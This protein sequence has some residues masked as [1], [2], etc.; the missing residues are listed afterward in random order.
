[1]SSE[2]TR[3][4]LDNQDRILRH[5]RLAGAD[6][7]SSMSDVLKIRKSSVTSICRELLDRGVLLE[8]EPGVFRSP[9]GLDPTY[10]KAAVLDIKQSGATTAIVTV[11]GTIEHRA[12][13][14]APKEGASAGDQLKDHA[15]NLKS[16]IADSGASV[17]GVGC[18]FPGIT[19]AETGKSV[20][21]INLPSGWRDV[22][23]TAPLQSA[24]SLGVTVESDAS[25]ELL[26]NWWFKP[27]GKEQDS[28][29]YL[30]IDEGI[31]CA[32]LNRGRLI[33][34][35][36]FAAGELGCLTSGD[37]GRPCLCGKRDC[38]QTYCASAPLLA[39]LAEKLGSVVG[40]DISE[41][42]TLIG[43]KPELASALA[44][45]LRPLADKLATVVALTD[46]DV[47]VIATADEAFT[48]Q[49]CTA[50]DGLMR[51]S[52]KGL[53]SEQISVQEGFQCSEASLLGAAAA[54]FRKSFT[55]SEIRV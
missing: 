55:A 37:E 49:I 34:G 53:Y 1:M 22:E 9:L 28:A 2:Q 15:R 11:D 44:I 50:L 4:R 7:R 47:L 35:R 20:F 10:F 12:E 3:K 14:P 45:L 32:Q 52:L 30:S 51:E 16:T 18:C 43:Q 40:K 21:A 46:P 29:I 19:Q 23:I 5:L 33:R 8:R 42:A 31:G 26:G 13:H 48:A 6:Q 36:H 17:L 54:V 27:W 38:L 41:V 24:L 25:C 39:G